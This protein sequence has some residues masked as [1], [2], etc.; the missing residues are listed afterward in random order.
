MIYKYWYTI[1]LYNTN[2]AMVLN[3]LILESVENKTVS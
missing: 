3:L 1:A 2:L